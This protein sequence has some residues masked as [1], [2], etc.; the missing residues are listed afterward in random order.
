MDNMHVVLCDEK[1]TRLWVNVS[2][3]VSGDCLKISGQ[4][5]GKTVE[6]IIGEDEYEYF[7]D[8][9]R[10]NTERL[11]TLLGHEEQIANEVFIKKFSGID[12]CK[13][14]REFCDANDIL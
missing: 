11:F 14:L 13:Y 8:F 3:K 10:E 4:D 9:D 1:T 12:G 6:D 7:Y 5:L 2:A